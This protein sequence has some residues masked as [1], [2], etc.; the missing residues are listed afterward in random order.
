MLRLTAALAFML[1]AAPSQS[2]IGQTE[3][4]QQASDR[5]AD[6]RRL[7]EEPAGKQDAESASPD[8]AADSPPRQSKDATGQSGNQLDIS[9]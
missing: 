6:G 3:E 5:D 2:A 9:G 8:A 4:D 7:W 1:V